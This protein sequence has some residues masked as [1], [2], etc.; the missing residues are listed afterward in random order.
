LGRVLVARNVAGVGA[1]LIG[2]ANEL[3]ADLAA[4]FRRARLVKDE[5]ICSGASMN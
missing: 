5:A 3:E 1:I 4:R 2:T